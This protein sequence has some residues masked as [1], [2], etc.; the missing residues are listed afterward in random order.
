MAERPAFRLNVDPESGKL[1]VVSVEPAVGD[2]AFVVRLVDSDG[3]PV[4]D[5]HVA[6]PAA[7]P[8]VKDLVEAR[9]ELE[10]ARYAASAADE[11]KVMAERLRAQAVNQKKQASEG[12]FRASLKDRTAIRARVEALDKAIAAQSA[13]YGTA[14]EEGRTAAGR[15]ES[16]TAAVDRA[17]RACRLPPADAPGS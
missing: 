13:T 12:I 10:A 8:R 2:K 3:K 5:V 9:K 6:A 15:V 14:V 7:E 17:E 16:A 1:T 11:K 4:A